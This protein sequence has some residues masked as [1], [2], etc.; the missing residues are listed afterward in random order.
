M[1][2]QFTQSDMKYIELVKNLQIFDLGPIK[3]SWILL[4][5][6]KSALS[7]YRHKCLWRIFTDNHLYF[8]IIIYWKFYYLLNFYWLL[9]NILLRKIKNTGTFINCQKNFDTFARQPFRDPPGYP[10]FFKL[11]S[12]FDFTPSLR[13]PTFF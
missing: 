10:K 13:L 11:T 8:I 1:G 9:I 2:N 5:L 3:C 12:T 6:R 4:Y 7:S